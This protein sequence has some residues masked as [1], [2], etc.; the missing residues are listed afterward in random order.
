MQSFRSLFTAAIGDSEQSFP[1]F[2]AWVSTK[3]T[4]R[5]FAPKPGHHIHQDDS[6]PRAAKKSSR[7]QEVVS[8]VDARQSRQVGVGQTGTNTAHVRE[9]IYEW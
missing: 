6:S 9:A 8:R 5:N 4:T 2:L 1:D 3:P 7:N